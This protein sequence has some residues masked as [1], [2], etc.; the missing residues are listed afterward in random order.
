MTDLP[1][2]LEERLGLMCIR[3]SVALAQRRRGRA[4]LRC[5]GT[6]QGGFFA[7][8]TSDGRQAQHGGEARGIGRQR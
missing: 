1:Q 7:H 2:M 5:R 3:C 4:Y 8:G 6:E